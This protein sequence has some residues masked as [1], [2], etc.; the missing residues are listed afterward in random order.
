MTPLAPEWVAWIT[1]NVLRGAPRPDLIA[2]LVAGGLD[3]ARAGAEIDAVVGSPILVGARSLVERSA[4][5][6]QAARLRRELD[7]D[8]LREVSTLTGDALYHEHWTANR[9]VVLRGAAR[10]WPAASW[11]PTSLSARFGEV[12]HA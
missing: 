12:V 3:E 7:R 10:D 4:A 9:P 6:E 2:G 8:P 5:I 11:T 1:A